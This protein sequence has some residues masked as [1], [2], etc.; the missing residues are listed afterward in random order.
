[1]SAI[2]TDLSPDARSMAKGASFNLAGLMAASVLG[3][4]FNLVAVRIVPIHDFGLYALGITVVALAQ[5]PALMGLDTATVRYVAIG[6]GRDDPEA[7]SGSVQTGLIASTIAALVVSA[8]LWTQAER[9]CTSLFDKPAG[10]ESVR[11]IALALPALVLLRVTIAGIQ[12]LGLM[13]VTAW[14][15]AVRVG[16]ALSLALLVGLPAPVST[17][18]RWR[19]R[20]P[21]GSRLVRR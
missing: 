12:G 15:P 5:I 19:G 20:R 3:V 17:A 16:A 18:L 9:I 7:I 1:M 4:A 6:A 14:L 8:V 2:R 11:I 13:R 10:A 21:P